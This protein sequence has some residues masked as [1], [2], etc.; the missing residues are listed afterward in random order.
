VLVTVSVVAEKAVVVLT[1]GDVWVTVIVTETTSGTRVDL[2]V[3]I[4]VENTVEILGL[5][6]GS[7][8]RGVL[9]RSEEGKGGSIEGR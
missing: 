9:K 8:Q 2:M 6:Q 7:S 1:A 3:M 4:D 5:L